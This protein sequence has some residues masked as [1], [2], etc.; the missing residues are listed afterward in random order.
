MIDGSKE[1]L[2][3]QGCV[4]VVPGA[5]G[6]AE[7]AKRAPSP[8]GFQPASSPQRGGFS[9]ARGRR[10]DFDIAQFAGPGVLILRW[11]A[12]TT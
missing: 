1:S 7:S 12:D 4:K 2:P 11:S 6:M 8:A 9:P 10:R 3:G 5:V